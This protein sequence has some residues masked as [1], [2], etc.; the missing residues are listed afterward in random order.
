MAAAL[1]VTEDVA[2][3]REEVPDTEGEVE[4]E[5]CCVFDDVKLGVTHIAPLFHA[6]T[7]L[8]RPLW[9]VHQWHGGAVT[10]ISCR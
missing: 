1:I 2:A 10:Q 8:Q 9:F 6:S 7:G 4:E 5:S 3:G